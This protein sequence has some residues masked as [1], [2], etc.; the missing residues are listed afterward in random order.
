MFAWRGTRGG[1]RD[2]SRDNRMGNPMVNFNVFFGPSPFD[3]FYYRPYYGY[4]NTP[5]WLRENPE[6]MG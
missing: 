6:E 2:V 3:V 4:Y 5:V 1:A